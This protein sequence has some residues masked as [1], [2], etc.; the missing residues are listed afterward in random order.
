MAL[1][2]EFAAE[3][4][5]AERIQKILGELNDQMAKL[6]QTGSTV[7]ANASHGFEALTNS[8]KGF[9]DATKGLK[10]IKELSE[11]ISSL[12]RLQGEVGIIDKMFSDVGKSISRNIGDEKAGHIRRLREEIDKLRQDATRAK[13][14]VQTAEYNFTL[15]KARGDDKGASIFDQA[16]R[17]NA[18]AAAR[19]ERSADLGEDELEERQSLRGMF[20][21][22]FGPGSRT[23][24]MATRLGRMAGYAG[25]AAGG[26]A[27]VDDV[28]NLAPERSFIAQ[29]RYETSAAEEAKRGDATRL[30]LR[31]MNVGASASGRLEAGNAV[32]SQ[33][34]T[35]VGTAMRMFTGTVGNLFS[36]NMSIKTPT[37]AYNEVLMQREG[38][39][40]EAFGLG[41]ERSQ[42]QALRRM[43]MFSDIE[44]FGGSGRMQAALAGLT[45]SGITMDMAGPMAQL[46]FQ[47]GAAINGGDAGLVLRQQRLG[48]GDNMMRQA[49]RQRFM[50]GAGSAESM[51]DMALGASGLT[52]REHGRARGVLGDAYGAILGQTVGYDMT[53]AGVGLVNSIGGAVAAATAMG[54]P[55]PGQGFLTPE[56]AAR[57]AASVYGQGK[58]MMGAGGTYDAV[59]MASLARMGITNPIDQ[60]YI[61]AMMRKN[62][63]QAGRVIEEITGKPGSG[64]DAVKTISGDVVGMGKMFTDP[65]MKTAKIGV[66]RAT[67]LLA[68]GEEAVGN[69]AIENEYGRQG[70][71]P[72][73]LAAQFDTKLGPG[74]A[75]GKDAIGK[76]IADA[77]DREKMQSAQAVEERAVFEATERLEKVLGRSVVDAIAAGFSGMAE[78]IRKSVDKLEEGKGESR[79]RTRALTGTM[80]SVAGP[81]RVATETPTIF[82]NMYSGGGKPTL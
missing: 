28:M 35:L 57:G 26:I 79:E 5:D 82:G 54:P 3:F 15:A 19:A 59:M 81:G 17:A 72:G 41:L 80:Q 75:G 37:E 13:D 45:G 32:S 7:G 14:A 8:L 55:V 44:R 58:S 76:T 47:S 50:G 39:D 53:G 6:A 73:A 31:E 74:A 67:A 27:L 11:S 49:A 4:K 34:G 16:R 60:Q 18:V 66:G 21:D 24:R 9:D 20:R 71:I 48:L 56:E 69:A 10:S 2:L 43:N 52:G 78:S 40:K 33:L 63:E 42:A 62:P 46:L 29:Q 36:G 61:A 12:G 1:R 23:G 77:S 68:G 51:I 22:Q 38:V 70:G 65:L 30:M 25:I 64:A